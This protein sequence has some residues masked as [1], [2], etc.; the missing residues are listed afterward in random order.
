MATSTI[1]DV[2]DQ[3]P[4]IFRAP[5]EFMGMQ[6]S[7]SGKEFIRIKFRIW[8]GRGGPLETVFR[9]EIIQK[10]KAIDSGYSD[11]MVSVNYEI[12]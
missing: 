4:G 7:P 1:T 6:K 2:E 12:A 10:F 5:P 11:W 3:F 8:P 9:Q